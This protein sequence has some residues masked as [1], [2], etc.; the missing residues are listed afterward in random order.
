[1]T[2][3]LYYMEGGLYGRSHGE[4]VRSVSESIKWAADISM[5]VSL[6]GRVMLARAPKM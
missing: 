6:S 5:D 1:V 3:R 4:S 2:Q